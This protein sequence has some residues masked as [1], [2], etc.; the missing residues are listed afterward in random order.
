AFVTIADRASLHLTTAMTLES[1]VNPTTV[2]SAWR[3]V[4]YKG[5]DNY[6]LAATTTNSS[7]PAGGG[8][9]SGANLNLYGPSKLTTNSWTHLA[10]TYD[11][12]TL[13]FYVN[14]TQVST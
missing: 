4:I 11:G 2:T 6:Y 14:G 10:F 8:T 12:T 5:N 7:R 1:W 9:Y 13:R 3:D